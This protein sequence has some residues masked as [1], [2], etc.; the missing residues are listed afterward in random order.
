MDDCVFERYS[1]VYD[2]LYQDKDYA[3]EARYVAGLLR[4]HAPGVQTVLEFGSGTGRH[5]RL[6]A[7]DGFKVTGIERSAAMVQQANVGGA[8]PM[9]G[10]FECRV[11]DIRSARIEQRF[12]AV[13]SLFHVVSYLSGNSDVLATFT[14]AA[15]HLQKGGIFIFDVWHGPAVLR[16]RPAVRIKRAAGGGLRVTRLAEPELDVAAST[17]KVCYTLLVQPG[18]GNTL[19]SFREEH[20]MRYFFP[21]EIDLIARQAGFAV[22]QHEEFLTGR[23]AGETTW[24]V[25][26]V[27]RKDT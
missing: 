11:G 5:G 16:E 22:V 23:P 15:T 8:E 20:L 6:L 14:N 12:D 2:L 24:G 1:A 7:R 13:I 26:Y 19:E 10:S 9:D 4:Q 3:A 27:L 17:V 21:Q 25:S 18:E